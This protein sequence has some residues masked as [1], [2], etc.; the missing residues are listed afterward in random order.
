MSPPQPDLPPAHGLPMS[1]G[2]VC[3]P[4]FCTPGS[5][6]GRRQAASPEIPARLWSQQQ[7]SHA[8][9]PGRREADLGAHTGSTGL[10]KESCLL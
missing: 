1:W 5:A 8:P 4:Q 7:Q 10:C 6:A 2:S 9:K 3:T